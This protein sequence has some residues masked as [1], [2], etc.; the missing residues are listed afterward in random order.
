MPKNSVKAI[1]VTSIDAATFDGDFQVINPTGLPESCF[2][3]RIVNDSSVIV[4]ISYD[5]ITAHDIVPDN[6]SVTINAQANS[7]PNNQIAN[8][9]KGTRIYASGEAGTGDVY[10]IGYYQDKP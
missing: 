3:L 2:L 4:G 7:A 9:A 6:D 5:G 1:P 10:V 8:F